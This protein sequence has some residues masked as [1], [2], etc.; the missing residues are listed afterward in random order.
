M[1]FS[2]SLFLLYFLLPAVNLWPE[3]FLFMTPTSSTSSLLSGSSAYSRDLMRDSFSI[4]L[5]LRSAFSLIV[6]LLLFLRLS[7]SLRYFSL[8]FAAVFQFFFSLLFLLLNFT[9]LMCFDLFGI[10][11]LYVRFFLDH[12]LLLDQDLESFNFLL[13]Y[14]TFR[15]LFLTCKF[16]VYFNKG[17]I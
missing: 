9:V 16:F 13:Q 2:K 7:M 8:S 6:L 10:G 3:V 11:H 12:C 4:S 5:A 17:F 15:C 1:C 14:G